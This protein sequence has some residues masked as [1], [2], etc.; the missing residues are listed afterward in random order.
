MGIRTNVLAAAL[1]AGVAFPVCAYAQEQQS[2][3]PSGLDE[4]IVTAQKRAENVQDV[5]IS[6]EVFSGEALQAFNNQSIQSL[7]SLVP[8]FYFQ[9]SPA[10]DAFYIRGFGSSGSNFGFEQ[11]VSLYQDGIYAGRARQFMAPFFDVARIEVLR[12]PQG[13]LLGK[14]TAA[15]AIS[16]TTNGP[17]DIFEGQVRSV[18]NFKRRG[19]D[20][21]GYISGPLS[22]KLSARLALKYTNYDGYIRNTSLNKKEPELDNRFARLSLKYEP[23]EN[24]TIN[25]KLE[26]AHF[27]TIGD[28]AIGLPIAIATPLPDASVKQNSNIFGVIDRDKQTSWNGLIQA[29]LS[30]GDHTLTS[31]TGYS[32]YKSFR[33]VDPAHETDGIYHSEYFEQFKQISQEFRLLSPEGQAFEYIVGGYFDYSDYRVQ[34][35]LLYDTPLLGVA[36]RSDTDFKQKTHTYS[37]FVAGTYH[38]TDYA[39]LRG[40]MRFTQIEKSG[41]FA[42]I[43]RS[44]TIN[45]TIGTPRTF[46]AD[47]SEGT[48]DPSATVEIDLSKDAMLYFGVGRGSK[49]GG[50]VSNVRNTVAS[51]FT[52]RGER[53]TNYEIGLKS[54]WLDGRL[55]AN[56]A[57]FYTKFKDLQLAQ[58]RADLGTNITTNAAGAHSRGVETTVQWRP[59]DG[60]NLSSS[61]A[62][63]KAE[64]DDYPGAGCI[65]LQPASCSQATNNLE[66]FSLL[67]VPK[68]SGN[69]KAQYSRPISDDLK[70][71]LTMQSTFKSRHFI[72]TDYSPAYGVQKGHA[73]LDARLELGQV[74]DRWT[75][76]LIG[77][78]LTNKVTS[79][80]AFVYPGIFT[81]SG[82]RLIRYIDEPR[83]LSIEGTLRF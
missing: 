59:F 36:G 48:F 25:T 52:F 58:Y 63:T 21:D 47:I 54:S 29:D 43:L 39:R 83:A 34:N 67:Y 13:A 9:P 40:S 37:A 5:A 18:Y 71:G 60:L 30:L 26:Y 72:S 2:D 1:L 24:L 62:Y 6:M 50:Y 17:T 77:T 12:G 8:N 82:A 70:V 42:S 16:I 51:G 32:R 15:G 46:S 61:A 73:K 68:W 14:N 4:I 20:T 75:V 28:N 31:I 64:Y 66:G 74:D 11:S 65:Q 7:T 76:A 23:N 56:A 81:T 53:S 35:P 33:A 10:N 3:Q 41:A 49:G 57:L 38:L 80:F 69:V 27:L 55:I 45:G 22:D 79:P 19:F 44:G 78:N